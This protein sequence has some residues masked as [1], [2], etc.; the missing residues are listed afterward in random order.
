MNAGAERQDVRVAWPR[1]IGFRGFAN[2]C[3]APVRRPFSSTVKGLGSLSARRNRLPSTIGWMPK[4]DGSTLADRM[5]SGQVPVTVTAPDK[6]FHDV[7][8]VGRTP[9]GNQIQLPFHTGDVFEIGDGP[10]DTSDQCRGVATDQRQRCP[11]S[12]DTPAMA[13]SRG[14]AAT[15]DLAIRWIERPRLWR[16]R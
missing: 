9:R 4:A 10:G 14:A 6:V 12:P 1:G 13:A 8:Q 2:R 3:Y 16:R 11:G 7:G 5:I 15:R